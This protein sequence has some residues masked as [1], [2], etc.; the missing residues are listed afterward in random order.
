MKQK[1]KKFALIL[2]LIT[3]FLVNGIPVNTN[4]TLLEGEIDQSP[5]HSDLLTRLMI[6]SYPFE[7]TMTGIFKGPSFTN[8][9]LRLISATCKLLHNCAT[10]ALNE[11]FQIVRFYNGTFESP[12]Q[13]NIFNDYVCRLTDSDLRREDSI[14]EHYQYD[15]TDIKESATPDWIF[16]D[17]IRAVEIYL[18]NSSGY[19]DARFDSQTS[20]LIFG[21]KGVER[22]FYGFDDTNEES[23]RS[24]LLR[25]KKISNMIESS[26][27][28]ESE[29][30]ESPNKR[31]RVH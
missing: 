31:I 15:N 3:F 27:D 30:D 20:L 24:E 13:Q 14:S 4:S 5:I 9:D 8:R 19:G 2:S 29:N 21:G 17:N 28:E 25:W 22:A 6:T 1:I 7:K 23:L 11:R 26:S 10:K 18:L 12:S 16:F